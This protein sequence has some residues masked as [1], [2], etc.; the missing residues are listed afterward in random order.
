M[1]IFLNKNKNYCA[2]TNDSI[3]I[4]YL[5][6]SNEYNYISFSKKNLHNY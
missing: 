4:M 6:V 3:N 2:Y 5:V 1:S